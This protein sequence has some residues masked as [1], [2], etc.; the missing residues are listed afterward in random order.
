QEMSEKELEKKIKEKSFEGEIYKKLHNLLDKNYDA[1]MK[2]K[3]QVSKN[4]AGYFLWN[5]WDKE[6]KTFDITKLWVGAQGTFGML[7][8]ADMQLVPTHKHREMMVL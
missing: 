7:L 5:V 2:A 3:P 6:K 1:I 8:E 4:S